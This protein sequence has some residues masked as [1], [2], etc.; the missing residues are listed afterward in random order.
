MGRAG[1]GNTTADG[2][3]RQRERKSIKANCCHLKGPR[4]LTAFQKKVENNVLKM[5][6]DDDY[7]PEEDTL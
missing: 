4:H 6:E 1:G 7:T 3:N 2:A 5:Y